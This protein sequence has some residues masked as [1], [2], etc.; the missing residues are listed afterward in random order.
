MDRSRRVIPPKWTTVSTNHT[1]NGTAPSPFP[2][3]PC[4]GERVPK[5]GEGLDIRPRQSAQ[6]AAQ[7]GNSQRF[8]FLRADELAQGHQSFLDIFQFGWVLR[9]GLGGQA[10]KGARSILHAQN[11]ADGKLPRPAGVSIDVGGSR[12]LDCPLLCETCAGNPNCVDRDDDGLRFGA[13]DVSID[14]FDSHSRHTSNMNFEQPERTG[15]FAH[16]PRTVDAQ[17][18]RLQESPR[19]F[20]RQKRERRLPLSKK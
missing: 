8:D 4:E 14:E 2:S 19:A 9:K 11:F 12:M 3:P 17:S 1:A 7:R 10:D 13:Q 20:S 18:G 15:R 6:A 5:A 16:S